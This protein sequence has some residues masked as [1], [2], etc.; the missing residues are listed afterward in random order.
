MAEFI[1][2]HSKYCEY[3]KGRKNTKI[4]YQYKNNGLFSLPEN[5][6]LIIMSDLHTATT[7]I[8]D[9]MIKKKRINKNTIIITTGDMAGNGKMGGDA[10]PYDDY[11]KIHKHAKLFYFVQGNHDLFNEKCKEL[12]NDDGTICGVDGIVQDTLLGTISGI[13]GIETKDTKANKLKHKFSHK[14]Y[15]KKLKF[16][17]SKY[18]PDIL[19]THQPIDKEILVKYHLP[20][21]HLCGHHHIDDFFQTNDYTMINLD[22]RIMEFI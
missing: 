1:R 13:N 22:G 18:N 11:L 10:D 20:K 9:D 17:L 2:K 3:I 7:E 21:Y 16:V 14:V 12:I 5:T 6:K 15:H 8:I 4:Y 19:L